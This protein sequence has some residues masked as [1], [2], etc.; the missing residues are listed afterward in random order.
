MTRP[1]DGR[2]SSTRTILVLDD[3][4]PL[5]NAVA[6]VLERSGHEVLTAGTGYEARAVAESFEGVIDLLICDLV[7]PDVGG[8]EV[9]SFL[10]AHN[11]G[12]DVLFTSGYSSR[13][14]FRVDLQNRSP[15][16][17]PKPF[18]L[19]MLLEAVDSI[20]HGRSQPPVRLEE[21]T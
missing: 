16:F 10:Q 5:R 12:M 21:A 2:M 13:G 9:S 8:R 19:P 15:A 3:D 6:R 11:P 18:D 4:A 17:L 20:L 1:T 7:L 14:S